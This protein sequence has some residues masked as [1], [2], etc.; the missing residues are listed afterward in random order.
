MM[1]W[2]DNGWGSGLGMIVMMLVWGGLIG[3]GVW[4]VAR[5]TRGESPASS[6]SRPRGRSWTAASPAAR[7][8]P[9][10]TPKRVTCWRAAA[11]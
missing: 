9:S 2:Y 4:A 1:G 3:L 7:S 10:S 11:R 6:R 5:L 8:T